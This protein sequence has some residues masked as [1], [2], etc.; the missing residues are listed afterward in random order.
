MKYDPVAISDVFYQYDPYHTGCVEEESTTEYDNFSEGVVERC[1]LL[2]TSLKESIITE[3]DYWF[4]FR[5]EDP[6]LCEIVEKIEQ[7]HGG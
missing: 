3:G 2:G 4:A 1:V 6:L 7:L 5:L